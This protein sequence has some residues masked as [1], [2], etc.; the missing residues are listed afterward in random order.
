VPQRIDFKL[1]VLTSRCLHSTALQYLAD[2]LYRVADVDSLR[3]LRTV[4][5]IVIIIIITIV[6]IIIKRNR[7]I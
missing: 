4:S 2:K 6:V 5:V 7:A 3:R 1:A